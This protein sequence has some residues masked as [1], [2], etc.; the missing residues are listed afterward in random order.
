MTPDPEAIV[1]PLAELIDGTTL[2]A[3]Q[4][5]AST[6]TGLTTS[7][8]DH[9]GQP[10]I[11]PSGPLDALKI[12]RNSATGQRRIREIYLN[13]TATP[14]GEPHQPL[15]FRSAAIRAGA[16][17]L[18]SIIAGP[19]PT[20]KLSDVALR[21]L[22]RDFDLDDGRLARLTSALQIPTTADQQTATQL[23]HL[24]ADIIAKLAVQSDSLHHREMELGTV[25]MLS[26]LLSGTQDL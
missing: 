1:G 20:P 7:I 19:L 26:R 4:E 15:V 16:Q 10:V 21:Q 11:G 12:L 9:K 2:R 3:F 17:C 6:I 8:C 24:L 14:D 23:L 5:G 13:L 22:A 18:G 25:H